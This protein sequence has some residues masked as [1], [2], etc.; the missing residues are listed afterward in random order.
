MGGTHLDGTAIAGPSK[1]TNKCWSSEVAYQRPSCGVKEEIPVFGPVT[2]LTTEPKYRGVTAE[3]DKGQIKEHGKPWLPLAT[4]NDH[5]YYSSRWS[6]LD[7]RTLSVSPPFP[8]CSLTPGSMTSCSWN[9]REQIIV[10]RERERERGE[11]E[12]EGRIGRLQMGGESVKQVAANLL[13]P[14]RNKSRPQTIGRS[15]YVLMFLI[16]TQDMN[17]QQS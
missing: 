3:L 5:R 17:D 10:S 2:S 11:R 1:R 12:R 6:S 16:E 9:Q 15:Q 8:P 7:T 4:L 14:S 13:R